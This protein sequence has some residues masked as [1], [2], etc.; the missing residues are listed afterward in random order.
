MMVFSPR[1][2][3]CYAERITTSI[4]FLGEEAQQKWCREKR[5]R[6]GWFL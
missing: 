2:D 3:Q 6:R 5:D 1:G 4:V